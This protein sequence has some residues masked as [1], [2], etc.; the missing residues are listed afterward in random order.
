MTEPGEIGRRQAERAIRFARQAAGIATE[1]LLEKV[2][3]KPPLDIEDLDLGF[4]GGL[5]A[6]AGFWAALLAGSLMGWPILW[7]LAGALLVLA[8]VMCWWFG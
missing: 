5:L 1:G 7:F 3:Q 4:R 6:Y 8:F 2:Q